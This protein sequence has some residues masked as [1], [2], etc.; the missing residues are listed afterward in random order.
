LGLDCGGVAWQHSEGRYRRGRA[1]GQPGLSGSFWPIR[2]SRTRI[3]ARPRLIFL[4]EN[5]LDGQRRL[6][7][8]SGIAVRQ[9]GSDWLR[10]GLRDDDLI[11]ALRDVR[12]PTFF[13]RDSDFYRADLRHRRYCL[14]VI[15]AGQYEVAGFVRRFLRH[16]GFN[17]QAKRM[18]KVIRVSPSAIAFWELREKRERFAGWTIK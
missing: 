15:E 10:K 7:E 5:I 6:V 16:R 4:D 14:A 9:V 3:G 11:I 13:T 18:G 2:R 1:V 8:V 12:D 17:T